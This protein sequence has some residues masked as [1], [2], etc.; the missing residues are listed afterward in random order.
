MMGSAIRRNRLKQDLRPRARK[1]AALLAVYGKMLILILLRRPYK[2]TLLVSDGCNLRCQICSIWRNRTQF[3]SLAEVK[4]LWSSFR[5]KPTWINISGGE[6]TLNPELEEILRFFLTMNRS[7][8]V[9]LTTNGYREIVEPMVR[10]LAVNR[11]SIL[12]VSV[13][14][15][16]EKAEHNAVRGRG[17]AFER[18]ASH[19]Q[20]LRLAAERFPTLK[21]GISTTVSRGN[22]LRVLPFLEKCI[23]EKTPV[24]INLAQVSPYY[25]NGDE[26]SFDRL[27]VREVSQLLTALIRLLPKLSLD[28]FLKVSF[29]LGSLR[30]LEGK[31]LRIPCSSI[32]SN[33][34][35]SADL[36]LMDCTLRF[37]PW[38][39][40]KES[41]SSRL[42]EI[43]AAI[44]RPGRRLRALRSR[45]R[46]S[47]CETRCHTPCESYVHTIAAL[48]SP[49]QGPRL[50]WR[51]L[52]VCM[53]AG[54]SNE[55][56]ETCG[57]S[58]SIPPV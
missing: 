16:G 4:H 40:A 32:R 47:G 31:P 44:R 23:R 21:V 33:V 49:W 3:I 17:D 54:R 9:T 28:S 1:L 14:M 39:G 38:T 7:L 29:L 42:E 52:M 6:P 56:A 41:R 35:V 10:V 53:S 15:D 46:Q 43:A 58:Q 45:I 50:V 36:E 13:S 25:E 12:Y 30:W 48:L 5:L 26:H 11:R 27:P 18:T 8:L 55:I 57:L 24:S 34:L 22:Y 19:Y 37:E 51:Y 20:A 2:L